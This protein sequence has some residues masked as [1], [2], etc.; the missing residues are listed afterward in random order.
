MR[1]TLHRAVDMVCDA[2]DIQGHYQRAR[3]N[4]LRDLA[5]MVAPYLEPIY[6]TEIVEVERPTKKRWRN[7]VARNTAPIR[8]DDTVLFIGPEMEVKPEPKP[9]PEPPK[10]TLDDAN[11]RELGS[12]LKSLG[13][14]VRKN[15]NRGEMLAEVN[16]LLYRKA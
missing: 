5:K 8:C 7:K 16:G 14:H 2:L 1:A 11:T 9:A 12:L 13:A 10:N 3:M 4:F 15:A 6:V